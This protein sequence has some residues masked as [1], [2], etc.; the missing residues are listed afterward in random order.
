MVDDARCRL[1]KQWREANI[2]ELGQAE[3]SQPQK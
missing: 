2:G 3:P 1:R